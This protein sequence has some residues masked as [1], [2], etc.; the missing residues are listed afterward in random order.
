MFR[1]L[2]IPPGVPRSSM[3]VHTGTWFVRGW[4]GIIGESE[5]LYDS[6]QLF[7]KYRYGAHVVPVYLS[8]RM[9]VGVRELHLISVL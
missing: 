8:R 3:E 5:R 1:M 6:L 4:S 9:A 7:A 2:T